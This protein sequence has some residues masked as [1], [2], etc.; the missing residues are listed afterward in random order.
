MIHRRSIFLFKRRRAER[1]SSTPGACA[2]VRAV[3]TKV[4]APTG[5]NIWPWPSSIVVFA[6]SVFT[7]F[8]MMTCASIGKW[9]AG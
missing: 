1:R 7:A 3:P 6:T 2:S 5:G 8:S 9:K 4:C